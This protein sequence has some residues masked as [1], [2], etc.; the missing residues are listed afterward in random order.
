MKVYVPPLEEIYFNDE[1]TDAQWDLL[2]FIMSLTKSVITAIKSVSIEFRLICTTLVA[3]VKVN[4]AEFSSIFYFSFTFLLNKNKMLELPLT[5]ADFV[6]KI[7]LME[8]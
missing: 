7:K 4:L 6:R 3:L 8:S 5:R 2:A 1:I